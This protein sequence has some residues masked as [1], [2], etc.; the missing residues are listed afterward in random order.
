MC[1]H[2][3]VFVKPDISGE[4]EHATVNTHHWTALVIFYVI[5]SAVNIINVQ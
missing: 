4:T 2:H 3:C 5:S 1:T